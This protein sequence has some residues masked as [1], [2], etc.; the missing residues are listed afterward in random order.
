MKITFLFPKISAIKVLGFL[1][2]RTLMAW[3]SLEFK[4]TR[5]ERV[6]I[7][8]V[9]KL[10]SIDF[11]LLFFVNTNIDSRAGNIFFPK[12]RECVGCVACL[13]LRKMMAARGLGFRCARTSR[14]KS[15][16]II[17]FTEQRAIYRHLGR[18]AE[19]KKRRPLLPN[20]ESARLERAAIFHGGR[21]RRKK[22]RF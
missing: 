20:T 8:L 21:L 18:R 9:S 22:C 15:H 1:L 11:L 12:V 6:W 4:N 19:N 14:Q 10:K 17:L 7:S 5:S 2:R 3:I 16:T 13:C